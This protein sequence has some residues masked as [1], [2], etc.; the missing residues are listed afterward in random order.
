MMAVMIVQGRPTE[1]NRRAQGVVRVGLVD[2]D[3][4]LLAALGELLTEIPG[5]EL[6]G[7]ASSVQDGIRLVSTTLIDVLVV[8]VRMP[9][10]GGAL[11][12]AG[13]QA[14]SP[15]T[16][17]IALSASGDEASR[18]EM[19]AAGASAYLVKDTSIAKLLDA[20]E[21]AARRVTSA[22]ALGRPA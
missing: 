1:W 7:A 14:L 19:A 10:G 5:L 15:H 13:A 9:G 17:V 2:D 22:S 3:Q 21:N 12:A 16:Q 20:L 18:A 8:D 6:G 4:L 11:V